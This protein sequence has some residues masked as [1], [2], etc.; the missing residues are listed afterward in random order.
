KTDPARYDEREPAKKWKSFK[1][2]TGRKAVSLG[3]IYWL[4]K[5]NGYKLSPRKATGKSEDDDTFEFQLI[6]V[7]EIVPQRQKWLWGGYIPLGTV[8]M[9]IGL[10]DVGKS[11]VFLDIV[12]RVTTGRPM[13]CSEEASMLPPMDVLIVCTEDRPKHT[14][15][16]RLEA[17]GAD[18]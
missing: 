5:S 18:R 3:T 10:P 17:A 9:L 6:N 8:T 16:P 11:H 12:A 13:P 4:A 7:G 1:D 2:R 15:A 14:L